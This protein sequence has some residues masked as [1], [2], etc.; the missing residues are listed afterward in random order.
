MPTCW[1]TMPYA[2]ESRRWKKRR[3]KNSGR[4]P[5][6]T[7]IVKYAGEFVDRH[8]DGGDDHLPDADDRDDAAE[9]QELRD[10]VDVAGDPG[11]ERR[12]ARCSG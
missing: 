5:F 10:L 6:Q 2:A 8:H 7:T 4:K 11:H 3:D 1:R 9:D 12:D